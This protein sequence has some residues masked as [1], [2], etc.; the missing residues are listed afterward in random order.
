MVKG[1]V[2][3]QSQR[4]C[5]GSVAPPTVSRGV[6]GGAV[7][8]AAIDPAITSVTW[9]SIEAG[10][11]LGSRSDPWR[12]GAAQVGGQLVCHPRPVALQ[13]SVKSAAAR[14][15]CMRDRLSPGSHTLVCFRVGRCGPV[16]R[17]WELGG[18]ERW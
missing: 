16:P 2:P 4:G 12:L 17:S 15:G 11:I 5:F 8:S 10:R 3:G 18:E 13:N 9:I 6:V 14:V 1:S 7:E